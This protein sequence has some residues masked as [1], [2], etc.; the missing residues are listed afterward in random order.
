MKISLIKAKIGN[1]ANETFKEVLTVSFLFFI[2]IVMSL[3]VFR[4][5]FWG[6]LR[7]SIPLAGDGLLTG[8]YIKSVEKSDY[9]SLIF[10]NI[11]SAQYGWPGKLDF[12][13]YPVGNTQEMLAIKIFMDLTGIIDPS[14]I[15]HIFSILKAAPIAVATFILARVLGI[16]RLLSAVIGL[17][18]TFNTYNL[19]RAEGHFFLAL[20]W[21]LPLGLSAIF[22]AFNQV[23]GG[24]SPSKKVYVFGLLLSLFSFMTGFYY[25]FFLVIFSIISIIFLFLRLN[26]ENSGQSLFDRTKNTLHKLHFP[27]LILLVYIFG[28]LL[29]TIP[30]LLRNMTTLKLTGLAD[31]SV[32]ESVI[33]SGT[34]ESLLF[35]LYSFGLRILNRPDL[36]AYLQTRISWEGAQV[37]AFSGAIL[38]AAFFLLLSLGLTKLLATHQSKNIH[39]VRIDKSL[40]FVLIMLSTSLLLYFVSPI[41][42]TV[43][44]FL[45]QIRA[46]GRLSVVISLLSLMLLGLFLTRLNRSQLVIYSMAMIVV[47]VPILEYN[48]FRLSRPPSIALNNAVISQNTEFTSTLTELKKTYAKNCSIVNLPL[49]PFPEFDHPDDMNIDYGQLQLSILDDDYFRWSYGGIK[50]TENFRVWQPLVSE[51]PPF[52][53]ASIGDQITYGN[54]VDACGVLVDRSYLNDQEKVDLQKLLANASL[55]ATELDGPMIDNQTRFVTVKYQGNMCKSKSDPELEK[56]AGDSFGKNFVWRVDQSSEIGFKDSYQMFSTSTSINVRLRVAHSSS[57]SGLILRVRLASD[58]LAVDSSRTL[59]IISLEN[60]ETQSYRIKFDTDGFGWLELPPNS[61]KGEVKRMTIS[62][63]DEGIGEIDTWGIQLG[64]R[65]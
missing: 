65:Y 37:G 1:Q 44:R 29:Q 23:I 36:I 48:Q 52:A 58:N 45:P 49:Y 56:L 55:C 40:I 25:S 24:K 64:T 51:F 19:V 8:L 31:R 38:V 33:Y 16:H 7:N 20:T 34:P 50:A 41:N 32:T 14:Q 22:I 28:L 15:I 2:S 3:L 13:S 26:Q 30:V 61:T 17:I 54:F 43:S 60:G 11:S 47:T 53:R 6:L 18:F 4:E 57:S 39:G 59:T 10:Q 27:I 42:L 12:T 63:T 35:D 62:L 9:A 5:N 21:S 46:W